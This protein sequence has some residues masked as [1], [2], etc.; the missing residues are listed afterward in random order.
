VALAVRHPWLVGAAIRLARFFPGIAAG[1]M[2]LVVG[3]P[4]SA[5]PATLRGAAA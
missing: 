4:R 5:P 3:T 1:V 2:P